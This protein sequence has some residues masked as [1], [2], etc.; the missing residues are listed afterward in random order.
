MP[1]SVRKY[2][3]HRA[4]RWS[5]KSTNTAYTWPQYSVQGDPIWRTQSYNMTETKLQYGVHI[6]MWH[7]CTLISV[8]TMQ[9]HF[10]SSVRRVSIWHTRGSNMTYTE[11]QY[12]FGRRD[13]NSASCLGDERAN[14]AIVNREPR[15][16]QAT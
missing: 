11:I 14:G 16:C 4:P 8:H 6:A 10:H 9:F 7:T 12:G 5:I 13:F 2:G 3:I 1:N 15:H